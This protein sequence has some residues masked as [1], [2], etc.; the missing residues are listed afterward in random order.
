MDG[1]VPAKPS[2][3][4]A[5]RPAKNIG[6]LSDLL[7]GVHIVFV[8]KVFLLFVLQ[9]STNALMFKLQGRSSLSGSRCSALISRLALAYPL[10]ENTFHALK[11][12][13]V[14]GFTC[15]G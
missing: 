11:S 2:C 15:C 12:A 9:E 4:D 6:V 5:D 10:S 14:S 1:V 3:H 13:G 7:V 8:T